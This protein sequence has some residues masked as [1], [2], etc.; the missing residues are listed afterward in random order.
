MV[1]AKV[2]MGTVPVAPI[3]VVRMAGPTAARMWAADSLLRAAREVV[4]VVGLAAQVVG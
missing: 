4:A 1:E 2:M 3:F